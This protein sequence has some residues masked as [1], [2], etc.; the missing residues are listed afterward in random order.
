MPGIRDYAVYTDRM[1]RSMWDKAFFMDKVPGTEAIVDYGCADGSLVCFL[2]GLFP[3]MRFIGFD[4]DPAMVAQANGQR[5]ENTW[6]FSDPEEVRRQLRA[7][8]ISGEQTTVNFS[9]VFHEIFS[10]GF[11]TGRIRRFLEEISPSYVTV[12]DMMYRGPAADTPVSP[13]AEARA[14]SA[15]PAWQIADF[16]AVFGS[17][18]L[19]RNLTHLL[20]KTNY[21]ENWSRECRENYF[22][23]TREELMA[24]LNP[25]GRFR[26]LYEACYTLPWIRRDVADRLGLDLGDGATTHLSLILGRRGGTPAVTLD[27]P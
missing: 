3:A 19:R 13:E 14:R 27:T 4:I 15:I 11:D 18:R 16:E 17:I 20:L 23:V 7:L 6:F 10:Y 25:A 5:R 22:S 26:V 21:T 24:V 8:G 2:S 9:S 12:R 1:R